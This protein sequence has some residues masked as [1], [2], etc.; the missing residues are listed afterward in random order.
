MAGQKIFLVPGHSLP[1]KRLEEITQTVVHATPFRAN[2]VGL[3]LL[4]V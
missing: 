4:V 3:G 2:A 1:E